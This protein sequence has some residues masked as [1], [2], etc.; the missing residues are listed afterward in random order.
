MDEESRFRRE[1]DRSWEAVQ[2]VAWHYRGLGYRVAIPDPRLRPSRGDRAGYGD[3]YD[4]EVEGRWRFEVKWRGL[5]FT[6]AE[7]FP[8]LTMMVDRAEKVARVVKRLAGY[9]MVNRGLSHAALIRAA[10]RP[11]W[12]ERETLDRIK[13]YRLRVLECPM[14]LV[15]IKSIVG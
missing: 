3:E 6:C 14:R 12:V 4:L 5:D 15:V 11:Q 7:D 13:G 8:Y 1:L 9:L 2:A 10:T